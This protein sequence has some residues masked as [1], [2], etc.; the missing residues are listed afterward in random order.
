MNGDT[1]ILQR[2]RG[3]YET[4]LSRIHTQGLAQGFDFIK[5]PPV[6]DLIRFTKEE[7][8]IKDEQSFHSFTDRIPKKVMDFAPSARPSDDPLIQCPKIDFDN[9]MVLAIISHELNCFVDLDIV[10]AELT[11]KAMQVLCRYSKPGRVVPKVISFGAYCAVVVRRF[12]G[13]VV[14]REA[15]D[16]LPYA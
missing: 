4:G 9:Q 12:D 5:A 13:K 2:F 15:C 3:L 14:F 11:S 8:V 6:N 16:E 1:L 7:R 10:A